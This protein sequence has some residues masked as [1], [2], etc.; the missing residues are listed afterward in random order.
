MHPEDIAARCTVERDDLKKMT[1]I[2]SPE[3]SFAEVGYKFG[4]LAQRADGRPVQY[5]LSFS[6]I[7][8]GVESWASWESAADSTGR[9]FE[10]VAGRQDVWPGGIVSEQSYALLT[11]EY[12]EQIRGGVR[13]RIY[14][15]NAI[16]DFAIDPPLIA[17]FLKMVDAQ[18][19]AAP[20]AA[21]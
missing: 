6:S 1:V 17:G 8:D 21:N 9:K 7:R 18:F 12:L 16:K 2:A 10:L 20:T 15:K 13:W 19:P 11:R 5:L 14:G 4:L 3:V